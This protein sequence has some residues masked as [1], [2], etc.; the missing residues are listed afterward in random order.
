MK[1]KSFLMAALMMSA[2]LFTANAQTADLATE[3]NNVNN[4]Y[5]Y[6]QR[7]IYEMNVGSMTPEG[8]F[9]AAADRLQGLKELGVDVVWLMPVYPR[10]E[11]ENSI[12]SPYAA[13]DFSKVNPKYGT[14]D[15]MRAFVQKAHS[16]NLEVWLDWVPNHCATDNVWTVTHPDFFRHNDDGTLFHPYSGPFKYNDVAQLDYDNPAL[17]EAM[18]AT[19]Q[20]WLSYTGLDG[21]RCDF[22]GSQFMRKNYWHETMPRMKAFNS[23]LTGKPVTM[24]GEADFHHAKHLYDA[25]WDYDY[26]WSFND[27]LLAVGSG[28]DAVRLQKACE[29]LINDPA[30]SN[31]DRMVYLTNHD[32]NHN[33]HV[34]TLEQ[35][36]GGNRYSF[37]VLT[38]TLYGMPLI[39]NGQEI[40]DLQ[41]L[42][43]FADTKVD[44]SK[45]D[46]KMASLLRKLTAMKHA[47]PAFRDGKTPAERGTVEFINTGNPQV[48]AYL[49]GQGDSQALVV[50]NL[51]K[52]C[53]VKVK[54]L[55]GQWQQ[56]L[57]SKTV[58]APMAKKPV[59]F[60]KT[61]SLKL[62]A[63][64][65]CVFVK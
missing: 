52:A 22:V 27:S 20:Y 61:Q 49:R 31:L 60:G 16:L 46:E 8:T 18:T 62:D 15:D 11:D 44:W 21:L 28:T 59:T 63:K 55:A 39:Y 4:R 54:G 50:L 48:L 23:P 45:R 57:D 41:D 6:G 30:Y 42:N 5:G 58:E 53:N 43:Y 37:S 17:A 56:W 33:D 32:A 10:G 47:V 25:G 1:T 14:I 29:V 26:A 38:F 64:G 9:N 36:F 3:I 24:L 34:H 7:V 40:G 12:D 35:K 2:S 65:Y 51:G 13:K 19:M